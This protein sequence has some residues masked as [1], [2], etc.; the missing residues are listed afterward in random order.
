MSD[1]WWLKISCPICLPEERGEPSYWNHNSC[2]KTYSEDNDLKIDINGNIICN[3]CHKE[4]AFKNFTFSCK[5]HEA[6]YP[7][8]LANI[9]EV[10]QVMI[11]KNNSFSDQHKFVT[12]ISNLCR[13]FSN[14]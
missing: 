14:N 12:M 4:W 11:S 8:N 7:K 3:G 2:N 10:M 13:M 6:E 5:N 1:K 9:L